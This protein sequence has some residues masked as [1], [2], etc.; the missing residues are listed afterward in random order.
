M[1][2]RVIGTLFVLAILAALFVV[3][4]E[5][6]HQGPVPQPTAPANDGGLK[7]ININ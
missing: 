7:P 6:S 5:P 4:S 2:F 3:T 1:K